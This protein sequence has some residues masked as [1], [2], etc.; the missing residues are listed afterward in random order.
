MESGMNTRIEGRITLFTTLGILAF[1]G[2][3]AGLESAGDNNRVV[4]EDSFDRSELGEPWRIIVPSF[5]IKDGRLVGHEEPERKHTTISRV[6]LAFRNAVF[7]FSFR[8]TDGQ[9][10]HLVINDETC[11]QA[12]SG[13]ICRVSISPSQVTISDDRD[14]AFR[15]DQYDAFLKSGRT[16]ERQLLN[17]VFPKVFDPKWWYKARVVLQDDRMEVIID[18][19]PIGSFRSPGIGHPTKSDFG[20]VTKGNIVEVDDVRVTKLGDE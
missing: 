14:G 20:F 11:E 7:E 13:H 4:F 1:G 16:I 18:G 2:V 10:L 9:G 12:H 3:A 19:T 6:P 8:L 5:W 17:K 15:A